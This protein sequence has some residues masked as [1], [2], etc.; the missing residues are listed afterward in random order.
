MATT[1]AIVTLL[2]SGSVKVTFYDNL[3][4]PIDNQH[5]IGTKTGMYKWSINAVRVDTL[6]KYGFSLENKGFMNVDVDYGGTTYNLTSGANTKGFNLWDQKTFVPSNT[7]CGAD[8]HVG[9]VV[10]LSQP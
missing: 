2:G 7:S 5:L 1:S 6:S 4:N 3:N 9:G 8:Q 10:L